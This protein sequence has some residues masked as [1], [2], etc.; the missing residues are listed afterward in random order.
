MASHVGFSKYYFLRKFRKEL[1]ITPG[2]FLQR[3]RIH[4]AME[5]LI[6]SNANVGIIAKDVGYQDQAAF[7]RAFL[8]VT[9]SQPVLYRL[10]RQSAS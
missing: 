4:M 5:K 3:Y 10:T 8:K 7:S 2:M 9:G 6:N 1:G